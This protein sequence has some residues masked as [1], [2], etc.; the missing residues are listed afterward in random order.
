MWII[1]NDLFIVIIVDHKY[2]GWFIVK[3]PDSKVHGA[4]MGPPGSC[5]PQMGPML[6]PWTL[7]SGKWSYMY[8]P[9]TGKTV[10]VYWTTPYLLQIGP[11]KCEF[12]YVSPCTTP[13]SACD[14]NI[15][16]GTTFKTVIK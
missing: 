13:I 5:R 7:L 12:C 16:T 9:C 15:I 1:D 11:P 14:F 8:D 4:H 2:G 3:I 6:A 10:Y